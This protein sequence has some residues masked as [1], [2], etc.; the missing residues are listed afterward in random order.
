MS[1]CCFV[2]LFYR[3]DQWT[4]GKKL[5]SVSSQ[6]SEDAFTTSYPPVVRRNHPVTMS[7]VPQQGD[8]SSS[9]NSRMY[10]AYG[11]VPL[12]ASGGGGA[13]ISSGLPPPD[14]SL[15]DRPIHTDVHQLQQHPVSAVHRNITI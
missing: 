3:N 6:E 15:H 9:G 1:S 12:N 11:N 14:R 2:V 13:G 10:G 5:G 7:H 4:G 8:P